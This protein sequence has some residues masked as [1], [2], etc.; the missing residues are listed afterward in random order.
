MKFLS[1]E[2]LFALFALVIPVIIHLFN[3]R[4]FKKVYFTNVQFLKEIQHQTSS[5]QKLK[6]ILILISRLLAVLFLVLAFAK[7]YVPQNNNAVA[8]NQT[9]SIYLDNSFSME[10]VNNQGS[11][12][13]EGKRRAKEIINAYSL[14]DKFQLLT[15]NFEGKQQRLLS[16]EEALS[17]ID[18]VNVSPVSRNFSQIVNRQNAFLVNQTNTI[19]NAYLISDFQKKNIQPEV[20]ID[21]SV[22]L[23]LISLK[24]NLLPNIS[25]DSAWFIS[26]IHQPNGQESMVV[27]VKNYSDKKVENVPITLTISGKQKAIGNV[28]IESASLAIDTLNFSG[29]D[30]G[31]Q[32]A[33]ISIKDYPLTFDDELF[34]SFEVKSQIPVLAIYDQNAVS[35]ISAVYSTDDFFKLDNVNQSQLNYSALNQYQLIVL[36]NLKEISLGLAQQLKLYVENGGSLSVFIPNDAILKTYES[37]LRQLQTDYPIGL[38]E[39]SIKVQKLNLDHP[40][41]KDVFDRL[42]QNLDLP[43]SSAYFEMSNQTKTSRQSLIKGE[44]NKELLAVFRLKKGT[45]YVSALPIE[46]AISNFTTHAIFLPVMFKMA[47]LSV[48]SQDIFSIIGDNTSVVL[49]NVNTNDQEILKLRNKNVEIIPEIRNTENGMQLYV[50]DQVKVPGFY[51]LYGEKLLSVL[52]YNNDRSESEMH[53][54]SNQN[55][56]DIFKIASNKIIKSESESLQSRIKESN[57]GSS[58]WKLC[59]ILVLIFL[60]IEIIL[61][62]FFKP[63]VLQATNK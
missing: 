20:S 42:P 7:P 49:E 56:Q 48:R 1:P 51:D 2:F 30:A 9:I 17:V 16:R 33:K 50:D 12:L 36:S 35:N 34:T 60:A 41:F 11:L 29:L 24:T 62:K 40:I 27:R 38:A 23:N 28:N 63:K 4:K 54:Y 10:A 3:F 15:N 26:P 18:E 25:V 19:R 21:S 32:K 44:N 5:S 39:K 22:N 31:W 59:L 37:F 57:L 8:A 45:I 55:L 61:I 6:D 13:D 58:L 47:L 43:A 52:A 46:P 53:Y 14:N